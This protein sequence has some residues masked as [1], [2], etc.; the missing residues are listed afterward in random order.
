[1]WWW[2]QVCRRPRPEPPP[3]LLH[4]PRQ[5][6]GLRRRHTSGAYAITDLAEI[7]NISRPTVYRTF[8][9]AAWNP[10]CTSGSYRTTG[11]ISN[12]S[13]RRLARR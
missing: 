8:T 9:R 4:D 5:Q 6:N 3:S 12:E 13:G 10:D 1:M 7:F 2:G 11:P